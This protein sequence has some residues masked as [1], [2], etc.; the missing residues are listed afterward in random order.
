M[1]DGPPLSFSAISAAL[2]TSRMGRQMELLATCPSTNDRAAELARQGAPE[3]TLVVADAQTGGRGRLGRTWH[4]PAGANLYLS[5]LLRPT[6]PPADVPP[7]TLLAGAALAGAVAALGGEPRLKWPNDVLLR[8]PE[9][10]RKTAG[11]LTEMASERDRVRHVVVGIGVNV[12]LTALPAELSD[13]ATSLRLALGRTI[14]RDALLAELLN[15]F[16]PLYDAFDRDGP[17]VAVRAW[18]PYAAFGLRCRIDAGDRP[19][20][21]A[22]LRDVDDVG[23]LIVEDDSGTRTRVLAGDVT[24]VGT[25]NPDR[26]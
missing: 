22:V 13:R 7:L 15:L 25:T 6:R 17:A 3:G 2:R 24:V 4:S 5:L 14:A 19:A 21:E 23:N 16:E 9:G 11:I 26:P 8:G 10:W 20:F 12:N 18:R 1:N